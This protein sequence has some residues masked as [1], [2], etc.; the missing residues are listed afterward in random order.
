MSS[1]ANHIGHYE[2][3]AAISARMLMAARKALW[4]EM[5]ELQKEYRSRVDMLRD[6]DESV[7][8]DDS[9]RIRKY[10]L[11]RQ[12]LADDAAIRDL[13][14]PS[15]ARLSAFFSARRPVRVLNEL[16]GAS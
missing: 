4:S 11:I 13:A 15:V 12:I 8:L 1:K 3:I 2:A 9:E 10:D 7:S 5:I 6:V 14:N 16:F